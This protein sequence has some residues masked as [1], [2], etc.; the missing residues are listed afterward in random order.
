[1]DHPRAVRCVGTRQRV[2]FGHSHGIEPKMQRGQLISRLQRA[3]MNFGVGIGWP[4]LHNRHF[5]QL[6][7]VKFTRG[8]VPCVTASID[9]KAKRTATP[10]AAFVKWDKTD[11][12]REGKEWG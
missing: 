6:H 1:M 9:D 3:Q 4:C 8:A 11:E 5:P 12:S 10:L 7:A 2:S